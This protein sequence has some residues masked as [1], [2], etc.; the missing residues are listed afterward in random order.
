MRHLSQTQRTLLIRH[1]QNTLWKRVFSVCMGNVRSLALEHMSRTIF[2]FQFNS[3][4]C[5]ELD[6]LLSKS[7]VRGNSIYQELTHIVPHKGES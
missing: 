5:S 6:Q 4:P 7:H 2:T 1:T 3:V